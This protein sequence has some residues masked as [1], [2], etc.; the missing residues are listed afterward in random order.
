MALPRVPS[1]KWEGTGA[2]SERRVHGK[3]VTS[4]RYRGCSG[5]V[6][7]ESLAA[8]EQLTGRDGYMTLIDK[9]ARKMSIAK[10]WVNPPYLAG[11]TEAYC[12][13]ETIYDLV[14]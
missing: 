4:L 11:E 8:P 6:V 5:V 10:V 2:L 12:L 3:R 9:T 14:I 7:R 13:P 1:G